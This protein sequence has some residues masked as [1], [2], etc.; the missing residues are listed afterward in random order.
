MRV[1]EFLTGEVLETDHRTIVDL[2]FLVELRE[3][4]FEGR[5][6]G[7]AKFSGGPFYRLTKPAF[8][9]ILLAWKSK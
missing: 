2:D 3:K 5:Y 6:D 7:S 1:Y 4:L 9:R 8:D